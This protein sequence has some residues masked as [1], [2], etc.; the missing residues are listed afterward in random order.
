MSAYPLLSPTMY[1]YVLH[2]LYIPPILLLVPFTWKSPWQIFMSVKTMGKNY[3]VKGW[4]QAGIHG[5]IQ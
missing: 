5:L 3:Q 2:F 1:I 4:F